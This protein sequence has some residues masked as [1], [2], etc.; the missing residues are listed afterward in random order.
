MSRKT[1][2]RILKYIG[3]YKAYVLGS[4]A[5][6]IFSVVS[7]LTGPTLIGRSI[8]YMIGKGE[9]DFGAVFKIL[10]VLALIYTCGSIFVWLL[11]YLT[12]LIS[13]KL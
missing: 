12:N 10:V 6:A 9:V 13:Y 2:I 5:A 3:K 8:D 7:S 4:L 1:F 11:T